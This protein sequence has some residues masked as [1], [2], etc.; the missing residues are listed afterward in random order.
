MRQLVAR[1]LWTE[2]CLHAAPSRSLPLPAAVVPDLQPQVPPRG[3]R[4]GGGAQGAPLVQWYLRPRSSFAPLT[5]TNPPSPAGLDWAGV[6][7]QSVCAPFIPDLSRVNAHPFGLDPDPPDGPGPAPAA[8]LRDGEG[9]AAPSPGPSPAAAAIS[10]EE[11]ARFA[12]YDYRTTAQDAASGRSFR[13]RADPAVRRRRRLCPPPSVSGPTRH[14][15]LPRAA[16]A[17]VA[18]GHGRHGSPGHVCAD[19]LGQAHQPELERLL[20]RLRGDDRRHAVREE[21]PTELDERRRDRRERVVPRVRHDA[22]GRAG[23]ARVSAIPRVLPPALVPPRTSPPLPSPPAGAC[24]ASARGASRPTSA[25]RTQ[26]ARCSRA[27]QRRR[28]K[29]H[30]AQRR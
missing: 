7:K 4:R 22:L 17:C 11:Q 9:V 14:P 21:P 23:A 2:T 25:G 20:R 10:A 1:V 26:R 27:S 28:S 30:T 12:G 3:A 19:S 5:L 6:A 16:A 8:A 13:L 15:F 29:T 18:L 24:A